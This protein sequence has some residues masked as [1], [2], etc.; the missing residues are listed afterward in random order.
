MAKRKMTK[1]ISNGL[2]DITQKTKDR[3]TGTPL[4]SC[5]KCG[6]RRVTLVTNLTIW[7]IGTKGIRYA[8]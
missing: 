8:R 7:T 2:Q 5:S 6:A 4:S 3:A 1:R